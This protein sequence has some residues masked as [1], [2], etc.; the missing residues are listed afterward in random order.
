NPAPY[1]A[2]SLLTAGGSIIGNNVMT[3]LC[4]LQHADGVNETNLFFGYDWYNTAVAP[5]YVANGR[6]NMNART[7]DTGLG[8][9]KLFES[10]FTLTDVSSPVTNIVVKYQA[11]PVAN[12][13]TF[14]MAV[15]A[16]A[17]GVAPLVTSGA[18]PATQTWYPTQPASFAVS[19]SGTAP[20]TNAWY[21]QN[22]GNYVPLTDGLDANGST[23][24]GSSTTSLTISNLTL[25]DATNYL[26]IASNAFGSA[27]SS[28]ALL[29]VNSGTP[30]APIITAQAPAAAYGVLSNHFNNTTFSVTLDPATPPP[31][32]YLWY[33]GTTP[34]PGATTANYVYPNT[35]SALIYCVV[36]NFV[37]A[38]T[39]APIAVSFY[40]QPAL[41]PY[42][43]AV[44]AF[45]P[46][47]YWPLTETNGTVAYDYAS[48]NDGAY[49]GNVALG[50]PGLNPTAGIGANTSVGFDGVTAYV[51]IP[52]RGLNLTNASTI[53]AWV[54]QNS[55]QST[56]FGTIL[57]HGNSSYR[58]SSSFG[59][60]RFANPGPDVSG[61]NINNGN[62]HQMVGVYDGTNQ[63]LYV[64]G[65][66]V[67][68]PT[69]G[70]ASGYTGNVWIG[71]AP[72]YGVG[73][74]NLNGN[75]AQVAILPGA[76][77]ATQVANIFNALLT[78]PSVSISPVNPSVYAGSSV[79]FTASA[80]G[81][82][83]IAYQWY[84][85]DGSSV[86]NNIPG[87]TNATY[88]LVNVPSANNGFTYGVNAVNPYGKST[89]STVISVQDGP[90]YS[91]L[92]LGLYPASA[93]AYVGAPV[94]Y[95]A[96]A[97]GSQPIYYQWTVNG[98]VVASGTNASYTLPAACGATTIQVAFTNNFSAGN[99]AVSQTVTLNGD[100]GPTNITFNTDGTSW[101]FNYGT[102]FTV[103]TIVDNLL[104]LTDDTSSEASAVFNY[105]AQYV[106]N[107]HAAFTY[108]A[109]GGADGAAF[110]LQNS[111][112]GI[113]AIGGSGGGLGYSGIHN[114]LAFEINLYNGNGLTVGVGLATN[115]NT[116]AYKSTAPV[117][118]GG[119]PGN[120]ID[121]NLNYV[122]G[123]FSASLRDTV[124]GDTF[125]TNYPPF[126]IANVLGGA[127]V[128]YVGFSGGDG[129]STS[130]Q[131]I[132]NFVFT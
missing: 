24:I 41:T 53:I 42:Q 79:L 102:V 59:Q 101:Q 77:T 12:S 83:P 15:S 63:T 20:I 78:P 86:S 125:T 93:E 75:I 7:L 122:N 98:V 14:I 18:L 110:I 118:V 6:V 81:T 17:G 127:N 21:V 119:T 32:G 4:I 28:P 76:L 60:S 64:D 107:F 22:N 121:V 27:T 131:T 92:G 37:G 25:A 62:W 73:V 44:F 123:V 23:I 35:N 124:T 46:V 48:T 108:Q 95:T 128:A 72:D 8:N 31:V 54:N 34:I 130:T 103:P 111:P 68:T 87:A 38:V 85:I 109:S 16:T 132:T 106:G 39:S 19:V 115:G 43:S 129:G 74:R 70:T 61:P 65:A 2:F 96:D 66:S 49:T 120:P 56:N 90:A 51:N 71:G 57:G 58:L 3:N 50:Q 13:T 116:G 94:T 10:Y 104:K 105:S 55:S 82:P 33:N 84:V 117:N 47:A 99:P 114:S 1:S 40:T 126:A 26:Y 67:G 80:G 30:T 100:P 113:G 97:A 69:V 112:Q 36:T 5:A 29:M 11:A 9:P 91:P 45:N 52:L 89:A 88:N